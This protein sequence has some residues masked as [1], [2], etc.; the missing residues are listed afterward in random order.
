MSQQDVEHVRRGM[1]YWL[2]TGKAL[3]EDLDP[4]CEIHDHDIMDA[5]RYRG[6]DGFRRWMADFGEA[7]ESFTL[8]PREYMDAGDGKVVLLARL[9]ARGRGSGIS[10]ERLDG[11]VWT[12][13]GGKTVRLDYYSTPAAALAA[14]GLREEA[15]S[16]EDVEAE[17]TRFEAT[18]PPGGNTAA[19]TRMRPPPWKSS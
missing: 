15:G 11:L 4:E 13:R 14:V 3:W 9:S 18:P 1:E 7:W 16:R 8:E 19:E 6:H 10:V 12:V 17:Y 5:G 2:R